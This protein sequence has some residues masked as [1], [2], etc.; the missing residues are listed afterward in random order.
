MNPLLDTTRK[1][2]YLLEDLLRGTEASIKEGQRRYLAYFLG[3]EN[4]LDVGCGRGEFLELLREAGVSARGIDVNPFMVERCRDKG[5][6]VEERDALEYLRALPDDGLGGVF[7]AQV[8]EHLAQPYLEEL[9]ETVFWKLSPGAALVAETVNPQ[10]LTVFSGSFYADPTHIKPVHPAMLKRLLGIIGYRSIDLIFSVP[11]AAEDRCRMLPVGEIAD[12]EL[13][14]LAAVV[15]ENFRKVNDVL[16]GFA[17]YAV[18]G[19]R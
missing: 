8:V 2:Y 15:N 14:A 17:N 19:L 16:F 5:L 1:N 11:T 4:V 18:V 3:R 12:P 10:N 9:L 7:M 6:S 13:R